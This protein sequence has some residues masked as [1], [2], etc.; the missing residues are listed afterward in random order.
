[1]L[2]ENFILKRRQM[3]HLC[4]AVA[5]AGC[6]PHADTEAAPPVPSPKPPGWDEV[7]ENRRRMHAKFGAIGGAE[8]NIEALPRDN[9]EFLGVEFFY[10]GSV[11]PFFRQAGLVRHG[12]SVS[13]MSSYAIPERAH[14]TWRDSTVGERVP[15]PWVYR[16]TGSI[17]G[18]DHIEVGS[19]V[20]QSV[21]D[22]IK[23][24]GGGLRLLFRMA[25]E[26]TYFGW[27]IIRYPKGYR[28]DAQGI[29]IPPTFEEADGDVVEAQR[30]PDGSIRK[31][32]YIHKKTGEKFDIL[33]LR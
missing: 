22:S 15:Y 20:P 7:Q 29:Y 12:G 17:V 13:S 24:K 8:L 30:L 11:V 26:G 3:I 19:R 1:M 2:R 6:A 4:G 23:T 9:T 32:W 16:Y 14:V 5:A 10:E 33:T 31:G 28:P 21:I 25:P 27:D 18:E